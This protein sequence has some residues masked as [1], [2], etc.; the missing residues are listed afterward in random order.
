MSRASVTA[1]GAEVWRGEVT[2]PQL[3]G[4]FVADENL[5]RGP[6]DSR[7]LP[8]VCLCPTMEGPVSELGDLGGA[9]RPH[10]PGTVTALPGEE[11]GGRDPQSGCEPP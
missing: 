5:T 8:L 6:P 4:Y 9:G 11:V 2:R 7:A 1:G 3:H 10:S